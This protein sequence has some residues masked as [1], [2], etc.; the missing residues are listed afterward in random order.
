MCMKEFQRSFVDFHN[1]SAAQRHRKTGKQNRSQSV[2]SR[3]AAGCRFGF[4][5]VAIIVVTSLLTLQFP[6]PSI[7]DE[8][9]SREAIRVEI[10]QLRETQQLSVGGVSIASGRS[11]AEFYERR[12]FRPTWT[13]PV[14]V[15]ELLKLVQSSRADGLD[16]VDYHAVEIDRIVQRLDGGMIAT[17][18]QTAAIDLTLTDSLIRLAYHQLYG[19]IDPSDLDARWNF[20]RRPLVSVLYSDL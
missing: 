8:M 15:R 14:K 7:A 12:D 19:R 3:A 1:G 2:L 4:H 16:P 6:V 9:A 11:L 13:D 20:N 17:A 10:E 5:R 18:R